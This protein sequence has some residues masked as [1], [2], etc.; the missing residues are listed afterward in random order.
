MA[1]L[2]FIRAGTMPLRCHLCQALLSDRQD[3]MHKTCGWMLREVGKRDEAV[4]R[5]FLDALHPTLP[6]PCVAA[7]ERGLADVRAPPTWPNR[8]TPLLQLVALSAPG[9]LL[10]HVSSAWLAPCSAPRYAASHWHGHAGTGGHHAD[11]HGR[12]WPRGHWRELAPI[13]LSRP[14]VRP[15]AVCLASCACPLATALP[16]SIMRCLAWLRLCLVQAK[17]R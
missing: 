6:Y 11:W 2:T 13:D 5:G 7:L 12:A 15:L 17:I 1:T 16:N 10:L 4:L 14:G 9:A 3:L 8:E